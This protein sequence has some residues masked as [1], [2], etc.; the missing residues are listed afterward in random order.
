MLG[1]PARV[2]WR[3]IW[4]LEISRDDIDQIGGKKRSKA[5][6]NRC[7]CVCVKSTCDPNIGMS[8]VATGFENAVTTGNDAADFFAERVNGA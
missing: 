7:L 8:Q 5:G 3:R 6:R 2:K 4:L 1:Q